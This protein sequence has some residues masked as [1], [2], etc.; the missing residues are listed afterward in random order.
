MHGRLLIHERAGSG[1]R[2]HGHARLGHDPQRRAGQ[3]HDQHH[4]AGLEA[5][6]VAGHGQREREPQLTGADLGGQVEAHPAAEV[7]Q[8]RGERVAGAWGVGAEQRGQVREPG[9]QVG[10]IGGERD[11]PVPHRAR[12]L[13]ERLERQRRQL[14]V[15]ADG[16]E[17]VVDDARELLVRAGYRLERLADE[18]LERA[19][20]VA[21]EV[22]RGDLEGLRPGA[23]VDVLERD[24]DRGAAVGIDRGGD[25]HR[26]D[27]AARLEL[28]VE[29]QLERALGRPGDGGEAPGHV[30]ERDPQ[31]PADPRVSAQR[32]GELGG[33][34][35]HV[36]LHRQVDVA[37]PV[38]VEQGVPAAARRARGLVGWK[39]QI[40]QVEEAR[41]LSRVAEDVADGADRVLE[42]RGVHLLVGVKHAERLQ[43]GGQARIDRDREAHW[44]R[45]DTLSA[46]RRSQGRPRDRLHRW[47]VV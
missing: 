35:D 38:G 3:R 30:D 34:A 29:R 39:R 7:E 24:D 8:R 36:A 26:A 45:L 42:P 14:P 43:E 20:E 11:E 21:P 46:V 37:A 4:R 16:P 32:R 27:R 6:A 41:A 33:H 15:E 44:G 19:D 9:A 22:R 2:A 13:R 18:R 31:A 1:G 17:Q 23:H 40:E 28:H 47:Q 12:V 10:L 5:P 25:P